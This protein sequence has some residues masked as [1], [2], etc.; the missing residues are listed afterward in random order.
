MMAAADGALYVA[1]KGSNRV[2]TAAESPSLTLM[3]SVD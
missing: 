1:K 2:G 3:R